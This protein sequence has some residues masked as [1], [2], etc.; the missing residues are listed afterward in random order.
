MS[1]DRSGVFGSV[2]PFAALA[3]LCPNHPES[4]EEQF[5]VA[6]GIN[7]MLCY[8]EGCH[9]SRR[10]R[11]SN[12]GTAP[13]GTRGP[14]CVLSQWIRFCLGNMA[15][16]PPAPLPFSKRLRLP[17]LATG[18]PHAC[19][20][21]QVSRSGLALYWH[22]REPDTGQALPPLY[23]THLASSKAGAGT[24]SCRILADDWYTFVVESWYKNSVA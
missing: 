24:F 4:R 12:S 10:D 23:G 17:S 11:D 20:W 14:V 6:C 13:M 7:I 16:W 5:C 22:G 3:R 2:S 9:V 21:A 1:P 19:W 8:K 15:Q 18:K